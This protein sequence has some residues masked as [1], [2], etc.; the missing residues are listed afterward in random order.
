MSARRKKW[1]MLEN[2][3]KIF[4]ATSGKKDERVFRISCQLKEEVDPA[5]LQK[6]LDL[7]MEDY[8]MF[9][10]VLRGGLFWNY[11]EETHLRP[12]VREEYRPPC[13][14]IYVRDQKNLLF[15]VTYYKKRINFETYHALTDGTGAMQFMKSL[16]FYYL[17]ERY[18]QW[19]TGSPHQVRI[20]ATENEM[21]EDSFEKYYSDQGKGEK[22]PK[23]KAHQMKFHKTEYHQLHLTEG[24]LSVKQMLELARSY[25]TTLTV[26]LTAVYLCAIAEEMSERQKKK[27]VALMIPVN[28][29]NY[30]PS[31]SV[32]NFFGW[33]DIGYDF[34]KQ[35]GKLEDVIAFTAQFFKEELTPERIAARMNGLIRLEKNPFMRILP[36][37]L[38]LWGMQAGAA[39]S[40]SSGTAVFSNIGRIQMPLECGEFIDWF[41]FYTTT[42]KMEICMCSYEDNLTISFTSCFSESVIEKNFFR[43]LTERGA[44]VRIISWSDEE[45][46]SQDA[47]L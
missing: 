18:P 22:I 34:S 29:R 38:K 33:I 26:Y 10:C 47:V 13:S 41:D 7:C 37:P 25:D 15:E 19:I 2:T 14:Q 11:L 31:D 8:P 44:N 46:G 5:K 43:M 45:G 17:K 27:P 6:A 16:V 3:A 9:L 32:R 12:A 23:Y 40:S 39:L 35:S 21:S 4:P 30:F 24:I 28:L 36:L 42:P 20:D 1:R